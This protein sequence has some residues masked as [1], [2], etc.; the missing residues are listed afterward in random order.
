MN[1]PS[2]ITAACPLGSTAP[3]SSPPRGVGAT[4][5]DARRDGLLSASGNV[6]SGGSGQ[7]GEAG[8]SSLS[9]FSF[10]SEPCSECDGNPWFGIG[11][12]SRCEQCEGV[13]QVDLACGFCS[14]ITAIDDDGFC[15][16]C[17]EPTGWLRA[18][19]SA[20]EKRV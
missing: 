20:L 13:G 12:G 14:R 7:T 1:R 15:A 17:L 18:E 9:T 4:P 8:A 19:L 2:R 16:D 3:A 10:R 5:I 11:H 6:Q